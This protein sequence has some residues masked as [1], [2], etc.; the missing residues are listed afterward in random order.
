MVKTRGGVEA[1]TS[2]VEA[3]DG[4]KGVMKKGVEGAERGLVRRPV[5]RIE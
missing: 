1:N 3:G 2:M 4:R 5:W